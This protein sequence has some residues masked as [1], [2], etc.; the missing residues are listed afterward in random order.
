MNL[1]LPSCGAQNFLSLRSTKNFDRYAFQTF[2]ISPTGCA[3]FETLHPSLRSE[4]R[5]LIYENKK[6]QVKQLGFL[7]EVT[8]FEPATSA[9]RI[10]KYS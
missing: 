5:E 9:S 7:V 8:G 2:A 3:R 1:R 10:A 6:I 4:H